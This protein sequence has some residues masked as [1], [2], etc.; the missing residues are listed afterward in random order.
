MGD[1]SYVATL[2]DS[3]GLKTNLRFELV[4]AAHAD[5]VADAAV[6]SAQLA[7]VTDALFYSENVIQ[8]ISGSATVPAIGVA[9][10]SDQAVVVCY[11][12]GS[13]EVAKYWNLRIPAPKAALFNADQLTIDITNQDLQDLV[14]DLSTKVLLSDGESINLALTEGIKSGAW[15]SVKK[16]P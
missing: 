8:N 6:I 16:N 15:R 1:F 10:I 4:Q 14:A 3:K 5:A 12:S 2:I 11:L 9:D 7:S 13:G